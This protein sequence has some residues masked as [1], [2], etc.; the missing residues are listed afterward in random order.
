MILYERGVCYL[1]VQRWLCSLRISQKFMKNM[2]ILQN[3]TASLGNRYSF[4]F[5]VR[6]RLQLISRHELNVGKFSP[7]LICLNWRS[8]V[9]T[10]EGV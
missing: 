4:G 9:S 8:A 6:S 5:L 10:A 3:E 2:F 7:M 1:R